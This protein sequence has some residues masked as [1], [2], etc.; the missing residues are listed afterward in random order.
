M[1]ALLAAAVALDG[2]FGGQYP[3]QYP[4]GG[5]PPGQYPPG[6]YPGGGGMGIPIPGRSKK[7]SN[8]TKPSINLSGKINKQDGVKSTITID[9][10]DGRNIEL[11]ITGDTK[12]TGESGKLSASDLGV[13]DQITIQAHTDDK[14]FFYADT[15]RVDQSAGV[16]STTEAKPGGGD[17]NRPVLHR[18]DSAS[19]TDSPAASSTPGSNDPDRPIL[20]RADPTPSDAKPSDG[21]ATASATPA[22]SSTSNSASAPKPAPKKDDEYETGEEHPILPAGGTTAS[23]A[24][25]DPNRPVLRRGAPQPRASSSDADSGAPVMMASAKTPPSKNDEPE[26]HTDPDAPAQVHY[27]TGGGDDFIQKAREATFEFDQKLPNFVCQQVVTR[28]ES[29]TRHADWHAQDLLSYDLVYEDGKEDYRN[30]KINGKAVKAGDDKN[31][32]S[33]SSGEFGTLVIDIFHPSTAAD[34]RPKGQETINH[35]IAKVYTF[36]VDKDH[37]HWRIQGGTQW[38]LPAYKGTIWIDKETYRALRIEMEA[39]NMPQ[40]FI[41]DHTESAADYDF[42]SIK[43]QRI[44]LPT[45]AEVLSC[46]RG[47]F[48]CSRNAIDFRNYHAYAGESS[49]SFGDTKP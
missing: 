34:F 37:S 8:N 46:E 33:W 21:N 35:R 30:P 42:V 39:I 1:I 48:N 16:H 7:T 23:T 19:S 43:D 32:G 6:Q 49:I 18:A 41:L 9:S 17:P 12:I 24:D 40:A 45:H 28:Y 38:I 44:L 5:Y 25:N 3:G 13:G 11:S 4:P 2:Q 10:D 29:T 36:A 47:T 20:R 22:P 31:S 14:G 15:I 26:I 27:V